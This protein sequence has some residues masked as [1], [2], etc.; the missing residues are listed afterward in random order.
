MTSE[1]GRKMSSSTPKDWREIRRLRVLELYRKR[2][3]QKQ[4][5]EALGITTGYVSQLVKRFKDLPDTEQATALKIENHAGRK[6]RI[7]EDQRH[8]ILML[9]D[10][11]AGDLGFPD[12]AWTL[13]RIQ[14]AVDQEL[15]IAVSKSWL[16]EM[17]E[18]SGYRPTA[19]KS[20]TMNHDSR[21][22]SGSVPPGWAVPKPGRPSG[23]AS[24]R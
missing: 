8:A 11:G 20:G 2:W 24:R 1:S 6:P 12:G 7:S 9:V 10:R 5:A 19:R 4:I 14:Q 15:G 13:R 21:A 17:L 16:A 18:A 22:A 3:S 23:G